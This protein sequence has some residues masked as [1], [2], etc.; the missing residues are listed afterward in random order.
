MNPLFRQQIPTKKPVRLFVNLYWLARLT[1]E[2][3]WTE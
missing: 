2:L 3:Q 1:S